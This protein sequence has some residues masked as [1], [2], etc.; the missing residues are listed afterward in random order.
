M[1]LTSIQEARYA[2]REFPSAPGKELTGTIPPA[3]SHECLDQ[4]I[5]MP[6]HEFKQLIPHIF[7]SSRQPPCA[8]DGDGRALHRDHGELASI[9]GQNATQRPRLYG[10]DAAKLLSDRRLVSLPGDPSRRRIHW[11]SVP[12]GGFAKA[13][14]VG[15]ENS[16]VWADCHRRR[17]V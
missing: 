9:H 7:H 5:F 3:G 11:E 6:T 12:L 16:Q 10:E 15:H 13:V 14:V 4:C 1:H 2:T 17:E 8:R